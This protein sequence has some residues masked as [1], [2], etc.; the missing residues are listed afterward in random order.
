MK[1][2]LLGSTVLMGCGLAAMPSMA[3]D[4]IKLAVGGYYTFYA[5]AGSMEGLYAL[6]GS[7]VQFKGLQFIQEGEIQ[8]TGQ[9]KLDNGTSVG[10][11]VELKAWNPAVTA[12]GNRQIDEAYMFAF[13]DWGRTEVGAKD[14][15]PYIMYY[16]TPSALINWGFIVHNNGFWW[17]NST[18]LGA[19]VAAWRAQGVGIDTQYQDANRINYY[20]PRFHGLQVGVSYAPK[21]QPQI[22]PGALWGM[23]PG[24]GT[25][26]GGVCGY[27]D[28]TT[29]SN[30]PTNDNSWQDAWAVGANYLNKFGDVTVAL[31]GAYSSMTFVPGLTP[32]ASAAN[33]VNGANLASWKQAAAGLQLAYG[34]FTLGGSY[35]WDNNGLGSNYYT[36]LDNDTRAWSAGLMYETGPWQFS[37][38][39]IVANN[40]N[41]NGTPQLAACAQGT[42]SACAPAAAATSS[43]YFGTNPNTGAASFGNVSGSY[44]ELGANYALGPGVKVLGG[45]VAYNYT[46]PSNA[47][48]GQSWAAMLGMDLRF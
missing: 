32:V 43:A 7:S 35:V 34:G 23:A 38:G 3:A 33:M 40:T 17:T 22:Q 16:G 21:I 31:Y 13:G 46:G 20:T 2:L 18:A 10:I 6:N 36:G 25:N 44:L 28:P 5:L 15:A 30:C 14:D 19:N 27:A 26:T 8:F 39:F 47:V 12:T 42:T 29:A 41:G 37:A 4:P 45:V 11:R 48:A 9:S 24:P 1:R